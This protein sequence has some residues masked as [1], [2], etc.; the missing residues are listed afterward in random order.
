[1]VKQLHE[2]DLSKVV[3]M[4]DNTARQDELACSSGGCEIA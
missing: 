3:E 1:M 4:I 2:I